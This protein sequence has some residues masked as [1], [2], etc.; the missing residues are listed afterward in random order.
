VHYIR[1][2]GKLVLNRGQSQLDAQYFDDEGFLVDY[3]IWNEQLACEIANTEGIVLTADHWEL[4]HLIRQFFVEYDLAPAMR[5]LCKYT[6]QNLGTEKGKSLY[7]LQ[8]FPGSPAKR[9]A[10]I[11]G[12]PKPENCL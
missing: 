9:L 6:A 7:L 2:H 3:A 4:I 5:P 12:L 8:L 10:K 1:A 11:A